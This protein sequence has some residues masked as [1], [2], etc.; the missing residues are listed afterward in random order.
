[1]PVRPELT[2]RLPNSPGALA[3][4]CRA[5]G[6]ERV[7]IAALSLEPAGRLHLVV[8]N[9]VRA[10]GA[11]AERHHQVTMQDVIVVSL[12]D[13]PGELAAVLTLLAG[14]GV[15]VEYTYSGHGAV[16]VGVDDALRAAAVAG[17]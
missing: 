16:V 13:S 9:P 4:V 8:D 11:L 6:D 12:A 3:N 14:A 10:S 1:M 7:N 17:V 2:L 15:N 5:L